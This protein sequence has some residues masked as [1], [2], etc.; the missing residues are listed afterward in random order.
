MDEVLVKSSK[1]KGTEAGVA[2]DPVKINAIE[3]FGTPKEVAA[4]VI[5]AE[6]SPISKRIHV[7]V[8]YRRT[9]ARYM[10]AKY[11]SGG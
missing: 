8:P 9:C 11:A 3:E 6:V 5:A 2:V 1:N 7:S 4:R 10:D